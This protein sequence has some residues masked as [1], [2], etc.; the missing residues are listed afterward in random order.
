MPVGL[1]GFDETNHP[2]GAGL[3]GCQRIVRP[4][5]LE[6][7]RPGGLREVP[8]DIGRL[9]QSSSQ[10]PVAPPA[11]CGTVYGVTTAVFPFHAFMPA[12]LP[13]AGL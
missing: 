2:A 10:S 1:W 4:K 3:L 5:P 13:W 8:P 6:P 11:P 9:Q 12:A 7:H